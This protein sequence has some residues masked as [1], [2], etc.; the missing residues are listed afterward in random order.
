MVQSF[1]RDKLEAI[2]ELCRTHHVKRL[3]VFGSAVATK[4]VP[5]VVAELQASLKELY[6]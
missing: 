6:R 1:I 5:Q 3:A 4:R 2:A